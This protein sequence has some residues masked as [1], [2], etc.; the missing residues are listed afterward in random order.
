MKNRLNITIEN[1]LLVQAKQ[2]ARKHDTS[3]SQLIEQYFKSL[4]RPGPS[5]NIIEM[6]E[7]LPKPKISAK[8]NLKKNYYEDQKGKY[9]F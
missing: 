7:R 6:V 9:G 4:N 3:L 5:E 1:D 2:Y 8:S